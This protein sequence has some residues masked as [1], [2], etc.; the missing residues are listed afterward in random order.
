MKAVIIDYLP[1]EK[2]LVLEGHTGDETVQNE[3]EQL[4]SSMKGIMNRL[5]KIEVTMKQ[6]I[7][8]YVL[9]FF[10]VCICLDIDSIYLHLGG[11]PKKV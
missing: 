5:D 1:F 6:Y 11:L 10:K 8:N 2:A 4:G 7:H 3:L 9:Q